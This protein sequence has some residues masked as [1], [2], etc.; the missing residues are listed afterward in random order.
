LNR[1]YPSLLADLL[2]SA[3]FNKDEVYEAFKEYALSA[4]QARRAQAVAFTPFGSHFTSTIGG[5]CSIVKGAGVQEANGMYTQP[6]DSLSDGVPHYHSKGR[7]FKNK[8]VTF[9]LYRSHDDEKTKKWRLIAAFDYGGQNVPIY[10]A[11]LDSVDA[12]KVPRHSWQLAI[13]E[14]EVDTI[15]GPPPFVLKID[16]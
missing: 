14:Q 12:D 7:T 3:L 10:T 4:E 8:A 11:C 13:G 2:S 15:A 6:I 16:N 9:K 1:I 5:R